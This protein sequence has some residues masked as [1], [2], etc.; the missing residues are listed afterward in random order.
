M[1]KENLSTNLLL[2]AERKKLSQEK[3]SELCDISQRFMGNIIRGHQVPTLASFEKICMGL[4]ESPNSLL[5]SKPPVNPGEIGMQVTKTVCR[6]S[7]RPLDTYAVC[8]SCGTSIER[9]YQKYCC[10]CGMKL[11]WKDYK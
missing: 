5:L 4:D 8:P 2:T 6:D 7:R 10:E 1:F 9:E 11:L 3:M